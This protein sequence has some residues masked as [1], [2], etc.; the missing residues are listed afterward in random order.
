MALHLFEWALSLSLH[1]SVVA[2]RRFLERVTLL[3]ET[4]KCTSWAILV[5]LVVMT[6]PHVTRPDLFLGS[7][8]PLGYWKNRIHNVVHNVFWKA[9]RLLHELLL[10]LLIKVGACGMRTTILHASHHGLKLFTAGVLLM[11]WIDGLVACLV[12]CVVMSTL[13]VAHHGFT[14]CLQFLHRRR[15]CLRALEM[16]CEI[17]SASMVACLVS[18]HCGIEEV[19]LRRDALEWALVLGAG[20]KAIFVLVTLR[21]AFLDLLPGG[22]LGQVLIEHFVDDFL[23]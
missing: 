12:T 3:F 4:P 11:P 21:T 9:P 18:C 19:A 8:L 20:G 13:F 16:A 15:H 1:A 6:T 14:E 10:S 7:Q 2:R 17:V 23:D 5:A 22:L